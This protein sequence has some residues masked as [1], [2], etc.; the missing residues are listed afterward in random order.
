[1]AWYDLSQMFVMESNILGIEFVD[2]SRMK[3]LAVHD[4]DEGVMDAIL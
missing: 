2:E 1:M 4:L 3:R